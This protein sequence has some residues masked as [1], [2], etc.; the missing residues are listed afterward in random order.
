VRVAACK[1]VNELVGLQNFETHVQG[2]ATVAANTLL[3]VTV[4][5]SPAVG[6]VA[7]YSV[8]TRTV[9]PV[10]PYKRYIANDSFVTTLS[11]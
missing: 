8:P 7:H 11:I 2:T 6:F 4:A 3:Q 1:F 9:A 10:C 5:F